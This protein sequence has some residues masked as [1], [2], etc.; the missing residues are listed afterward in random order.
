MPFPHEHFFLFQSITSRRR[1]AA[2][3]S[4][5]NVVS[6]GGGFLG[7]R[8]TLLLSYLKAGWAAVK[9]VQQVTRRGKGY[10]LRA[11]LWVP[12][13]RIFCTGSKAMDDG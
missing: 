5:Y 13:A 1:G 6:D 7:G 9:N 8:T 3:S 11:P 4:Q 2:Q 10:N 12:M